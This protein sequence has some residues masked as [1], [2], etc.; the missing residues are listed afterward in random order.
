MV[1][2]SWLDLAMLFQS[3]RRGLEIECAFISSSAVLC[4]G[5]T[6]KDSKT[7]EYQLGI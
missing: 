7:A 4:E 5:G 1:G 3:R 2:Y 6:S